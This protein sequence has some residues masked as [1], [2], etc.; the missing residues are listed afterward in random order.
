MDGLRL[1]LIAPRVDTPG[2]LTG[3][4]RPQG[5]PPQREC[6]RLLAGAFTGE[7][8][9]EELSPLHLHDLIGLGAA[10]RDDLD[11][12]AFL[13][14]DQRAG[15]RRRDRDL[16]GLRVGLRLADDLPDRF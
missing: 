16:A 12:G 5:S 1:I 14:A 8:P 6:W 3:S 7:R 11:I 10:R 9:P 13:L 15:E 2:A 4:G